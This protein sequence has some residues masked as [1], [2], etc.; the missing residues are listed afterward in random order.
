MSELPP[1]S[2][3]WIGEQLSFLEQLCLKSFHDQGHKITLYCYEEVKGIPKDIMVRDAAT[4][5][6]GKPYRIHARHQ[7]P[8]IHA[9]FFRL[10]LM[11]KGA[12]EIWVD[13]DAYCH[14]PFDF[15]AH[16]AV[17]GWLDGEIANGVMRLDPSSPAL[18]AYDAFLESDAPVPPWF[19]EYD[20]TKLHDLR[21][22]GASIPIEKMPW[23]VSGPMALTYF[24]EQSGEI[25]AA[26]PQSVFYPMTWS[27]RRAF[28][29]APRRFNQLVTDNTISFHFLGRIV[30]RILAQEYNGLPKPNSILDRLCQQHEID[31]K[32]APIIWR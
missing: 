28:L 26:L 10:K 9:D 4:I 18:H 14:K 5:Y 2:S 7:S 25:K 23:G 21:R 30:R 3:L 1:I 27:T 12:G 15:G 32:A 16:G 17:F 31:P 13:T 20:K 11:L 24:L 6:R 22:S 29:F 19:S 8:A